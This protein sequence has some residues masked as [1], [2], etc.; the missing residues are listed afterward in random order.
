MSCNFY[1]NPRNPRHILIDLIWADPRRTSFWTISTFDLGDTLASKD[2][3]FHQIVPK[4]HMAID[5]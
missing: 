1:P 5:I 2:S 3:K 4:A